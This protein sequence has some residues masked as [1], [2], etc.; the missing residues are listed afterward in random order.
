MRKTLFKWHSYLALVAMLPLIIASV[1]GSIL[2]FKTEID[3]LLMPEKAALNYSVT[4]HEFPVRINHN[5]L[6]AEIESY[7]PEYIIGSW[8]V[9]SD[10]KEADRVYLIKKG[11]HDWYKIYFDPYSNIVLSEPVLLTSYLT[12]WLLSLHYTF[13]LN[14][15]GGEHA[16]WGTFVGLI[17][18]I[19][20]TFLGVSGLI[21][22]RRFWLQLLSLRFNKTARIFCGDFHRLAGVWSSPFVLVLGITGIYFNTMEFYHEVFEHGDEE[23]Y[24]PSS[25]LYGDQ[26]DFQSLLDDSQQQLIQFTPTYL[27]YPFEPDVDI[28]VFGYL[29]SGNPFASKYSSTVTYDKTSGE[30]LAA[31][32][33]REASAVAQVFDSFRE[34]HFGS[35]AGLASKILW[36]FFG[37]GPAI[38]GVSGFLVWYLRKKKKRDRQSINVGPATY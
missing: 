16:Q 31:I 13:L 10:G 19:S 21:I 14:G 34:L 24:N 1:T 32:D 6:Q 35:F 11:D 26:I 29:P 28:T 22:H 3:Q 8:E 5:K 38:L 17:A 4:D 30:L 15:I 25:S 37:L 12:D 27:L 2:V 33:G 7:F 20:L 18:A 36:C 9:F 23:H